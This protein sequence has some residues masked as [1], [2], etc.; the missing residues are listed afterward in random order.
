MK[1]FVFKLENVLKYRKT[2][3]GLAKD[4]YSEALRL[5]NIE[6]NKLVVLETKKDHLKAAYDVKSGF[7]TTPEVLSF[8]DNY[9]G[10]LLFLIRQQK[11]VTL[12]KEKVAQEKFADWNRKRQDVEIIKRLEEKKKQEYLRQVAQEEQK[13]Q[14]EIFITKMVREMVR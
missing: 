2:L 7:E 11:G 10:Q 5:L 14:D 4:A 1:R 3:E 9:S 13:F 8:L 12:E 6:K